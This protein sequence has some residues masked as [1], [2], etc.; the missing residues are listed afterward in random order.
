MIGEKNTPRVHNNHPEKGIQSNCS[1]STDARQLRIKMNDDDMYQCMRRWAVD[2]YRC[3]QENACLQIAMN[4]PN[5]DENTHCFRVPLGTC[6]FTAQKGELSISVPFDACGNRSED[7]HEYPQA[8]ETALVLGGRL[9]Y[10]EDLEELGY[11]VEDLGY[12]DVER[13]YSDTRASSPDNVLRLKAEIARLQRLLFPQTHSS[14]PRG[15]KGARVSEYA[16][17]RFRCK[18]C[19]A[20]DTMEHEDPVLR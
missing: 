12:D 20:S 8:A 18:A 10:R 17:R 13:W 15:W 11:S 6:R 9:K 16:A 7:G 19:G 3:Q 4:R 5:I 14:S 2:R 1:R